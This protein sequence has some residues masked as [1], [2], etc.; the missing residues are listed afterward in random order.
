MSSPLFDE[1]G[2]PPAVGW[3]G[4]RPEN[5]GIEYGLRRHL[6]SFA[7]DIQQALRD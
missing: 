4:G 6:F 2:W 7:T 3:R 5:R 1:L